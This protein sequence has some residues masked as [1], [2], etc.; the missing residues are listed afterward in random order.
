MP[1]NRLL[2]GSGLGPEEVGRLNRAYTYALRQLQL[3]DRN[4]PIV[5]IVAKKIIEIGA[6]GISDP[7]EI[8][9]TAVKQLGLPQN[10]HVL[11][12]VY[13]QRRRAHQPLSRTRLR[14]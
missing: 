1:I 2:N 8:S 14:R 5:D 11:P 9:K 3:V 12:G 7:E 6:T 10:C 13:P 4:D